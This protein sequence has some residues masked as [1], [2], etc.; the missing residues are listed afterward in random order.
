L[1]KPFV[2]AKTQIFNFIDSK[3]FLFSLSPFSLKQFSCNSK[4]PK[5]KFMKKTINAA[6]FVLD[7]TFH[8]LFLINTLVDAQI[9]V[10]FVWAGAMYWTI[11]NTFSSSSLEIGW[12]TLTG[13]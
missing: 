8:E 2:S 6:L 4:I 11:S 5:L 13:H 7:Y 3:T 12:T 10:G 9:I 1:I